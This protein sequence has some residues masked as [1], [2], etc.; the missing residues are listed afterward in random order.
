MTKSADNQFLASLEG[1]DLTAEQSKR[2]SSGIQEVVMRELAQIDAHSEFSV[3]NRFR[4]DL[5]KK[6]FDKDI[7]INGIRIKAILAKQGA[8]NG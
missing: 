4:S 3:A 2:I 8:L 7:L 1:I 5:L 6:I